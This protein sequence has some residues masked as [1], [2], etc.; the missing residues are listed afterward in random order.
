MWQLVNLKRF[1]FAPDTEIS[2]RK[3]IGDLGVT[4]KFLIRFQQMKFQSEVFNFNR[5]SKLAITGR[6]GLVWWVPDLTG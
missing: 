2:G 5:S 1:S 4:L 3:P 6:F